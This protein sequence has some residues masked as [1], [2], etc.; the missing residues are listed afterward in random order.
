MDSDNAGRRIVK[1]EIVTFLSSPISTAMTTVEDSE[2]RDGDMPFVRQNY[3]DT[4]YTYDRENRVS[5]K[6]DIV[7]SRATG[8]GIGQP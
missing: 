2:H 1:I 7:R 5:V 4:T 8:W 3:Q 6:N